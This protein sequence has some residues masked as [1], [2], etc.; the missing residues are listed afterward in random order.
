MSEKSLVVFIGC[1]D[2][3]I[4]DGLSVAVKYTQIKTLGCRPRSKRLGANRGKIEIVHKDRIE[5][6]VI[7]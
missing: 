6:V 5:T 3:Q 2:I 1:V 4:F 7:T